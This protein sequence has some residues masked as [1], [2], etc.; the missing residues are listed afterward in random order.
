MRLFVSA[1]GHAESRESEFEVPAGR[2]VDVGDLSLPQAPTVAGT[3]LDASGSPAAGVRLT[4]H[5][6]M[7]INPGPRPEHVFFAVSDARGRFHIA[8]GGDLRHTVLHAAAR[9]P[10][11]VDA[12]VDVPADGDARERLV[13][14]LVAGG[15]CEGTVVDAEGKP[16]WAATVVVVPGDPTSEW[17]ASAL[18][19]TRG[20]FRI[21]C[22]PVGPVLV[23]AYD[24]NTLFEEYDASAESQASIPLPA[25]LRIT[26]RA[27][28]ADEVAEMRTSRHARWQ[29]D[30]GALVPP[31]DTEW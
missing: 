17:F 30:D 20:R 24:G 22:V 15:A 3:V 9:H 13:L 21:L 16:V 18:T 10:G 4:L 11:E 12:T 28:S 2:T 29:R 8:S 1:R 26:L 27:A 7:W 14:R 6:K 25:P 5:P 19:D 23:G 31:E